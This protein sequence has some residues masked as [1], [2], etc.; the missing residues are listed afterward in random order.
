MSNLLL[1]CVF[2]WWAPCILLMFVLERLLRNLS[3]KGEGRI[4]AG[5]VYDEMI[6][7]IEEWRNEK[8]I[9]S[10]YHEVKLVCK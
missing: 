2:I 8:I 1:F 6:S 4:L 10:E 9:S 7:K 3:E 5:S